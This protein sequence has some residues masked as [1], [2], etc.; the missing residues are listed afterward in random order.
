MHEVHSGERGP[1]KV[2]KELIRLITIQLSTSPAPYI[3]I[4]EKTCDS[5]DVA[6]G[7]VH[8][9]IVKENRCKKG[10]VD[11]GM[12]STPVHQQQCASTVLG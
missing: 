1:V 3:W 11:L 9:Y 5:G 8:M 2:G 4:Q 12:K 7:G 6:W 10:G